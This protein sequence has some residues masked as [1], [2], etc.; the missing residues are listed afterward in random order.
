MCSCVPNSQKVTEYDRKYQKKAGEYSGRNFV[1]IA[2]KMSI[3][4]LA[5]PRRGCPEGSLFDS[6]Y[7]EV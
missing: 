6:Y 3:S 5:G 2:T 4:K 1:G 7:T